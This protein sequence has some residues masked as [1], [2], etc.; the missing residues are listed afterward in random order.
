LIHCS[1]CAE[2]RGF[3]NYAKGKY[4]GAAEVAP[5][6][7]GGG[8]LGKHVSLTLSYHFGRKTAP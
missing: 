2:G 7:A 6:I 5:Y 4:A 3:N 8:D 1:T